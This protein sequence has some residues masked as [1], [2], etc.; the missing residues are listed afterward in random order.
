MGTQKQLGEHALGSEGPCDLK[1]RLQKALVREGRPGAWARIGVQTETPTQ[2]QVSQRT[3]H[4]K[5][6]PTPRRI[7]VKQEKKA[8]RRRREDRGLP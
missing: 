7:W 5:E 1:S 6:N 3:T 2:Y 4:S 8:V